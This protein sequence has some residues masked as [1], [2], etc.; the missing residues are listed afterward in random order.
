MEIAIICGIIVVGCMA[1]VI[2]TH[3]GGKKEKSEDKQKENQRIT[4]CPVC[5]TVNQFNNKFCYNCH[6]SLETDTY[7]NQ[8]D[9]ITYKDLDEY[10]KTD[11]SEPTQ[12]EEKE[13]RICYHCGTSFT[14]IYGMT[15]GSNGELIKRNLCP[16]CRRNRVLLRFLTLLGAEFV[17][18]IIVNLLR[19]DGIILGAIPTVILM[20]V[21]IAIAITISNSVYSKEPTQKYI[22]ANDD[23]NM[24]KQC[25]VRAVSIGDT[26]M[27][28]SEL[29]V[30][31]GGEPKHLYKITVYHLNNI[32]KK[33]NVTS[34]PQGFVSCRVPIDIS[35][36]T[37]AYE[38]V[39]TSDSG[40]TY[41]SP[42][43]VTENKSTE[44]KADSVKKNTAP[45]V[46]VA[47]DSSKRVENKPND[48]KSNDVNTEEKQKSKK[49]VLKTT[50]I[51]ITPTHKII[52]ACA[53]AVVMIATSLAVGFSI[54]SCTAR[55]KE[56]VPV[57][58]SIRSVNYK[59]KANRGDD[60]WFAMNGTPN[61]LYNITVY[62]DSGE[63]A[64]DGLEPQMSSDTGYVYWKWKVGT[65]TNYG[66]YKIVI[67]G[68]AGDK[69]TT[70]FLVY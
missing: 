51:K 27:Q 33:Y 30:S 9:K 2:A 46:Q 54:G 34:N 16:K 1:I 37:G 59:E 35:A 13:V 63:S 52:I 14:D 70:E 40:K 47:E 68:E 10:K 26:V 45:K 43:I 58:T 56:T 66:T 49:T 38:L 5:R 20:G 41:S 25:G 64:A 36:P 53:I 60:M 42:F 24:L 23:K 39:I 67:E 18:A 48:S 69:Y 3:F 44:P 8:T 50:T 29:F 62:Y 21:P 17:Y 19:A 7:A 28:G 65:N 6:A 57:P 32:F 55:P 11:N 12:D 22:Q 61:S 31:F 15:G 4:V